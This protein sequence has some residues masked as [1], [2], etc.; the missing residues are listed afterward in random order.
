LA[1]KVKRISQTEG[2]GAGYDILSFTDAGEE[3]YIEVK[4]TTLGKNSPFL[5][6]INELQFSLEHAEQFYLYR[7]F[8]LAQFPRLFILK[9]SLKEFRLDPIQFRVS[10]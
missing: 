3:M 8:N 2:D 4:A 1:E 7:I 10:F 6:S 5:L 9:G